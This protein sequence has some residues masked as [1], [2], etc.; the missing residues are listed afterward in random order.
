MINNIHYSP[1]TIKRRSTNRC[2]ASSTSPRWLGWTRGELAM[3]EVRKHFN[4]YHYH[5]HFHYHFHDRA[6]GSQL[7]QELATE[8]PATLLNQR[9]TFRQSPRP[10]SATSSPL[11]LLSLSSSVSSTKSLSLSPS[12]SS[13]P[14]SGVQHL[15][16]H[17]QAADEGAQQPSQGQGGQGVHL[18]GLPEHQLRQVGQVL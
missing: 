3:Q 15:R 13:P 10:W 17:V 4:H 9:L 8:W 14:Y 1:L 18:R 12:S 5:D 16:V 6:Q 2:P 7:L 11:S